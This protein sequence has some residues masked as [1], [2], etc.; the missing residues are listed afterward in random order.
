MAMLASH[1]NT[2]ECHGCFETDKSFVIVMELCKG[3]ELFDAVV[4]RHHLTEKEAAAI[5][6]PVIS[7][8]SSCHEMGIVHRC[9]S[10][11]GWLL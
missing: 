4:K 2:I 1:P 11:H 10:G 7:V 9:A 8:V 5:M 3:G 6:K